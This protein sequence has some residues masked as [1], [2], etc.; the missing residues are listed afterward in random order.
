[1]PQGG[2]HGCHHGVR[3]QQHRGGHRR[4]AGRGRRGSGNL[5][6]PAQDAAQEGQHGRETGEA[7]GGETG[8]LG[9]LLSTLPQPLR[10]FSRVQN[11]GEN[12]GL[13][14]PAPASRAL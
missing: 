10:A 4:F 2:G 12:S 14:P 7:A 6:A 9:P 13:E 11:W 1:M 5:A 3:Q 8:G